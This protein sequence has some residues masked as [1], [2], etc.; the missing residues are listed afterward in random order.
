ME[1]ISRPEAASSEITRVTA[2]GGFLY[3]PSAPLWQSSQGHHKSHIF[4]VD[5]YPWIHLRFDAETLKRMCETGEQLQQPRVDRLET[6]ISPMPGNAEEQ[7]RN[8]RAR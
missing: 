1:H 5:R 7:G 2:P 4:D 8:G 3:V 6:G